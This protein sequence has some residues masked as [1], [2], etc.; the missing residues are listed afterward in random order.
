[1]ARQAA[2]SSLFGT[3]CQCMEAACLSL[4]MHLLRVGLLQAVLQSGMS[5]LICAG[6]S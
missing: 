6:C 1:M 2:C 5:V 4:C 3:L